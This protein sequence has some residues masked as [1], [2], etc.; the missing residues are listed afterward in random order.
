MLIP[1]VRR[2]IADIENSFV[3]IHRRKATEIA[4]FCILKSRLV[5]NLERK[6][7]M[8]CWFALWSLIITFLCVA[9][10]DFRITDVGTGDKRKCATSNTVI[11]FN[12]ILLWGRKDQ[13]YHPTKR[14]VQRELA[15]L[16]GDDILELRV[17]AELVFEV[18]GIRKRLTIF[19]LLKSNY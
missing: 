11:Y 12:S 5:T 10:N 3:F 2:L 16:L 14:H 8:K 15:L 4:I 1:F 19:K 17:P 6:N 9:D 7:W 18:N 13:I